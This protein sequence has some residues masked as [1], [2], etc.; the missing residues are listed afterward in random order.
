[1]K[2]IILIIISLLLL[3]GCSAE[4]NLDLR[5]TPNENLNIIE[6]NTQDDYFNYLKDYNENVPVIYDDQDPDVTNINPDLEYYDVN[7]LS[8][9]KKADITLN[10]EYNSVDFNDSN[11]INTCYSNINF[12]NNNKN[13]NIS[14]SNE[15]LCFDKYITLDEVIVN[16]MTDKTIKEHNADKVSNN[17]YT[18]II[19]KQ[20]YL[21]KP[22]KLSSLSTSKRETKENTKISLIIILSSILGFIILIFIMFTY[23]NRK[24]NSN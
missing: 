23:K 5:T 24:Y 10:Y 17:T 8:S 1:M 12:L 2:K 20:N 4:Y 19:T 22:I 13:I 15:F 9:E 6:T 3:T 18:W 7:N 16:I 11:I 21:N 14:T